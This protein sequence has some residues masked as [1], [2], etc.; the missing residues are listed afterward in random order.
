M[1]HKCDLDKGENSALDNKSRPYLFCECCR[2][3]V[4]HATLHSS[5]NISDIEI[6]FRLNILSLKVIVLY[7]YR[8]S[9]L[10]LYAYIC[11]YCETSK[12]ISKNRMVDVNCPGLIAQV[13]K[14][15]HTSIFDK[16]DLI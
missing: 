3:L 11:F 6:K 14:K 10:K 1:Y 13:Y 12:S 16:P 9:D 4:F 8:I 2:Q 5:H 7:V 15:H